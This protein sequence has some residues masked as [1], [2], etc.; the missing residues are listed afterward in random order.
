M[1]I[2]NFR[3]KLSAIIRP[4]LLAESDNFIIKLADN[5]QEIEQAQQLRYEVF[6]REQGRLESCNGVGSIDVDEYDE[7][8]LHLIVIDKESQAIVGTYRM[9][10]GMVARK[11]IGFYS[12][13]EYTIRGLEKIADDVI[14]MGRSCVAAEYRTGAVVSLLWAGIAE[15]KRRTDAQY[16]IGCVSLE[17]TDSKVGWGLY[18]YLK[19]R[20]GV[21][22]LLSALPH[23][24][25]VLPMSDG[26]LSDS[27]LI[28]FIPPLFKGYIRLGAKICGEPVLDHEFGSIDFFVVMEFRTL[29]EKY[30]RH[31]RV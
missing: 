5:R 16:L 3:D 24:R 12:E 13:R 18:H 23:Q 17:T 9:H 7:Y 29:P 20:Y 8:C 15:I 14:E 2:S 21:S 27:E 26:E 4:S 28:K 10:P 1:G 19:R 30:T 22:E 25:F 6:R 11:G 31:Y